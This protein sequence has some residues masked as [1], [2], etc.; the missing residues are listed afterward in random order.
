MVY[1]YQISQVNYS[2]YQ[3]ENL[4]IRLEIDKLIWVN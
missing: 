3:Y 2:P 1:M 4:Q